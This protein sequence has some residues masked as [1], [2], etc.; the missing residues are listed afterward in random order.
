MARNVRIGSSADFV[1]GAL[2]TVDAEGTAVVAVRGADGVCAVRDRCSHFGL[3]LSKGPG[4]P[5][6]ADGEI[7]CP[8][9]NSRFDLCTGENRDWASGFAGRP[10]PGWSQKM[11]QMG[12][13]PKPLTTYPVT[14]VDGEVF[15]E[16]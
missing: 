16:L 14:E 10:I 9:H 4:T 7:T 15:I 2:V 8:W 3:P 13:K 1:E 5:G 12:R 6:V 11:L